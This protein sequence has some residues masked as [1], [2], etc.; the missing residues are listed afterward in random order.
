VTGTIVDV[1][2]I[3]VGH[4]QHPQGRTGCTVVLCGADGA[5]AGVDV[6]GG[7]PGT[8]ETDALAPVNLIERAHAIVLA[9]GSAFGLEAATGVMA[10]LR[11][12]GVGVEAGGYRVPIVA[13]AVLFDLPF[14]GGAHPGRDEG[15]AAARDASAHAVAEGNVGAGC[16][17]TVGKVRGAAFAM[18]TGIGS[19]SLRLPGGLV[20]G[21]IV[22]VNAL[23]SVVDPADGS[24]VAG[25][26]DDAGRPQNAAAYILERGIEA[27]RFVANTT[28][29]AVA[30]NAN[31]TK[32]QAAKLASWAHDA[33]ARTIAPAHTMFDGDTVF[34]LATGG[35]DASPNVVGTAAVEAL[36]QAVLRAAR[37]AA[38]AGGLPA[39]R[40]VPG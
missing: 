11:E 19:A 12:R 3:A 20:V 31:L 36:S 6:R 38:G 25:V 30:T 37:R 1:P 15:Y 24:V 2:G 17:A 10:W 22:A 4:A 39:S 40:D 21:A 7:A 14:S 26:R 23:G 33:Y 16:G 29:G 8:R 9:G 34:A 28:I 18:K 13:A 5:V 35:V 27:G 32:A